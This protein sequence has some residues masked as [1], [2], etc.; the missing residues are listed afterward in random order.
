MELIKRLKLIETCISLEDHALINTQLP[1]LK[2]LS[3]STQVDQ[4]IRLLTLREYVLAI[5]AITQYLTVNHSLVLYEDLEM[6]ALRLELKQIEITFQELVAQR[7]DASN[8]CADFNRE[9]HLPS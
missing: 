3:D 7:N 4:I 8:K 1:L 5:D 6:N 9:Y 2:Q